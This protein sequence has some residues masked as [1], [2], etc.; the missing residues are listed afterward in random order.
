MNVVSASGMPQGHSQ[1]LKRFMGS[2]LHVRKQ[3][4]AKAICCTAMVR[5]PPD[6]AD[7]SSHR[8]DQE[9]RPVAAALGLSSQDALEGAAVQW[10][11]SKGR[12]EGL[13]GSHQVTRAF[14]T[15]KR[16]I[17]AWWERSFRRIL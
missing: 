13:L 17:C 16:A 5:G 7:Q 9:L 2:H 1:T 12:I 8:A 3:T 4:S 6:D 15:G 11:G 10:Y 14:K